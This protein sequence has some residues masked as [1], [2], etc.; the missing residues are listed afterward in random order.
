[1]TG[2]PAILPDLLRA[3]AEEDPRAVA[4]RGG[5]GD[6]LTYGD[7]EA[8]ANAGARGL[9]A[10]GVRRGDRVALVFG[11][12]RWTDYAVAYLAVHK[13]GGAAVPLGSR[14]AGGELDAIVAHAGARV[15]VG[16][17][18]APLE[19]GQATDP[20]QVEAGPDDVAEILYTSGTTG[21][22]KG[23]ACSHANLLAHDVPAD[24]APAGAVSFV[25]AFP[26]GT[27]AAQET[28]R[29]PLRVPG[30]LAI[31]LA[32]FD[33]HELCAVVARHRVARLQLVPAMAHVLV[34]SGAPRAHDVSSVRRVV[35]S[36][37]PAAPALFERLA[38][39][40]PRASVWNAYALTEAGPARTMTQWDPSRP[41]AV[42]RPVGQTEVRIVDDHGEPLGPGRTGEILLRRRGTPPR[43]YHDEP[44]AT[45]VA[46]AGGWVHTG[47]V[48]H[49]DA[50]GVLHLTDHK[51]D[52]ILSGGSNVSSV[53]VENALYEHPAVVDA[54][55][56]GVPHAT[57]GE[58]VAAAVV[59]RFPTSERELQ[60]VV[61][62]R[63]A[64]HKV[65]HRVVLVEALPRN[66]S[67]KVLKS[68]VRALVQPGQGRGAAGE[69]RDETEAVV[70]SVWRAVLSRPD[71]GIHD[72][73]F[74]LGGESL[75]AAQIAARLRDAFGVDVP[76][77]VVFELPTVAE[78]AGAVRGA[79]TPAGQA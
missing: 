5:N 41:T 26:I 68:E 76:V 8:R 46:F 30:R 40:F 71:V 21:L 66:G 77:A 73:F 48:G 29:V 74:A 75:A 65:P 67:G 31:A 25:H 57:L 43:W 13:A 59:V 44:E 35:L 7:W 49:V 60:D 55:V 47:D 45:A 15:T 72:D 20:V 14:F 61:R 79:V 50:E 58:D 27:Q 53:E 17:A 24:G 1:M 11:N 32:S 12:D 34:A 52:L 56:V 39:A 4:L 36:S 78:L 51:K 28:L 22:P 62:A 3:R 54:A 69:P 42:G 70:C 19:A 16:P 23:V 9:V 38:R 63:L 33:P 2:E 37:A 64:E 18:V 6:T 10:L